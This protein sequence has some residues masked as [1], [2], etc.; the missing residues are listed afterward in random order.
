MTVKYHCF[1]KKSHVQSSLT[2]S[3]HIICIDDVVIT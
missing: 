3:Y 1:E 2:I